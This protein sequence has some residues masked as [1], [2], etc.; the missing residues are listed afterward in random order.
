MRSEIC[1]ATTSKPPSPATMR[2]PSNRG[3]V[4]AMNITTNA[5]VPIKAVVP[6]STSP[7]T[8]A[9]GTLIIA[10]GIMV[11]ESLVAAE[12]LKSQGINTR[13]VNMSTIK[14][15][16]TDAIIAAAK[17]GAIATAEDHNIYGGLGSAV[18]EVIAGQGLKCSFEMI[19]V[20]DQF[21]ESDTQKVLFKKYG[22][23]AEAIANAV[24]RGVAE[25][26]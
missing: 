6:R 26:K 5:V 15:I 25:K 18:A 7:S 23:D 13:V 14:P 9:A 8:S 2:P 12:I 20:K 4:P 11:Q 17:T 21:A 16:D 1:V 19:G 3:L 22:L 10:S 24:M